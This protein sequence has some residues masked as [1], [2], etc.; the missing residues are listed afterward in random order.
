MQ[1]P[2]G[3]HL[4][5]FPGLKNHGIASYDLTAT[6]L[7]RQLRGKLLLRYPWLMALPDLM[8]A[9]GKYPGVPTRFHRYT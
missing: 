9:S 7:N 5:F 3:F 1:S 4:P 2:I 8:D 6:R